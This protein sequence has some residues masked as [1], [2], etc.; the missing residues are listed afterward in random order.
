MIP[1]SPLPSQT[2]VPQAAARVVLLMPLRFRVYALAA[3]LLA[4]LLTTLLACA[5]FSRKS[6]A[7]GV[8]LPTSGLIPLTAPSG[9]EGVSRWLIAPG[10][11]VLPGTPLAE[12]QAGAGATASETLRAPVAGTLFQIASA[13]SAAGPEGAAA[14]G[15]FAPD[16]PL[17]LQV[18]V[19]AAL[20]TRIQPGAAVRVRIAGLTGADRIAGQVRSIAVAPAELPAGAAG[21]LSYA[22]VVDL[23]ALTDPS[24]Q[25]QL[26]GL[27]AEVEFTLE[28][29]PLYAWLFDPAHTL[30]LE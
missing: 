29:R 17:A 9:T 13:A 16:G 6:S 15:W 14:L 10:T 30:L 11:A 5:S 1:A 7:S 20:R 27:P 4:A 28:R 25:R 24:Q 26:L 12:L 3:L 22:V 19:P 18:A 23:P 2:P 8:V 21:G